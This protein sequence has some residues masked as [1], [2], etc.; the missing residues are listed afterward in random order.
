[1]RAQVPTVVDADGLNLLARGLPSL[2]ASDLPLGR[3]VL[4]PHPAEAGRLLDCSTA[5]IQQDRVSAALR[6][7]QR[8]QAVVV[9]KGCGTV[10]AD[11]AGRYAICPLGNPGMA[12][13][14]S[15]D[16]LS[17]VIGALLAQ[18]LD[19]WDAACAGVVAHAAAGDLAASEIGERGLLASDITRRL[20]AVLNP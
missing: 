5:D 3:W 4:T 14:G 18:G 13:A 9:L 11:S 1:M 2:E 7:A 15:G 12:T 20:P 19:V 10:V 8:Y 17:G 16:V 6:L